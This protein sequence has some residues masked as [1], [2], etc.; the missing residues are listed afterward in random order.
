MLLRS[1]FNHPGFNAMGTVRELSSG[2]SGEQL[3]VSDRQALMRAM[4]KFISKKDDKGDAHLIL[5]S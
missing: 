5:Q 3:R 1:S 2:E 4:P